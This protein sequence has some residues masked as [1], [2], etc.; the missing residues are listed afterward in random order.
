MSEEEAAEAFK[1]GQAALLGQTPELEAAEKHFQRAVALTPDADEPRGW[2]A[3]ALA[4]GG[5]FPEAL[6]EMKKAVELA[7]TDPRHHIALGSVFLHAGQW[8]DAADALTRGLALGLEHGEAEARVYLAQAF[9]HCGKPDS[10][11][12]QWKKIASIDD[13]YPNSEQLKG[14]A[15]YQLAKLEKKG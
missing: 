13:S 12:E 14:A 6:V 8:E 10:A 3:A 1:N 5:K 15:N 2:L 7:P 9:E 11:V 4:Q